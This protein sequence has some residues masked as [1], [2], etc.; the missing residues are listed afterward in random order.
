MIFQQKMRRRKF[1][2][3]I[4]AA[5]FCGRISTPVLADIISL[6]R[7]QLPPER[8]DR[9][10]KDYLHKMKNYDT[11]HETDRHLESAALRVLPS[12]LKRLKNIQRTVGHGNFHLLNF[13]EAIKI[14][15]SYSRVGC[16]PKAELDL[17]EMLFY[18]DA[19]LY[20]FYGEKPLSNMTDR[21]Q[22]SKMIKISG[23]GNYLYKGL[24]FETYKKI[25]RDVG[26]QAIL[27]SGVRSIIK[28]FLLFLSKTLY[29]KGN[30][31]L[32]SRSLAPP[33]YSFHGVGDFDIG[34]VGFGAANFTDQ[35]ETTRVYKKLVELG[36]IRFRYEKS[37]MLGVRYEPWHITVNN[38][39]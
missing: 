5:F 29:N 38:I 28:Q 24:P 25:K 10:I 26:D 21:V 18:E 7:T 35:F 11:L 31:S 15:S 23:S 22:R 8:L 16:F 3:I 2:K 39:A 37:N 20:G 9:H 30:L 19:A 14:A 27:T 17:L 13:D 32:A 34:Q 36:Y 6:H 12:C 4:A 1:L 33:G